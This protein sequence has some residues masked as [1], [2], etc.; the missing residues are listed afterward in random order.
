MVLI[1]MNSLLISR[2]A[3]KRGIR[4]LGLGFMKLG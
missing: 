3:G 1:E 2:V 4:D